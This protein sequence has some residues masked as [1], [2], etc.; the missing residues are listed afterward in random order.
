[1]NLRNSLPH[2]MKMKNNLRRLTLATRFWK[3]ERRKKLMVMSVVSKRNS[4]K[5]AHPYAQYNKLAKKESLTVLLK[6]HF[7]GKTRK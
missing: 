6:F 7:Y 1:M 2:N 5:R 4:K 3:I